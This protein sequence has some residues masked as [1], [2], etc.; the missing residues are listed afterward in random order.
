MLYPIRY[1]LI[2][3]FWYC[4]QFKLNEFGVMEMVMDDFEMPDLD[5]NENSNSSSQMSSQ[6]SQDGK[7]GKICIKR[8]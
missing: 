6:T 1:L 4:L 2:D 8:N 5:T 3:F 7:K